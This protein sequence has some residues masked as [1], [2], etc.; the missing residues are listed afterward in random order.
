MVVNHPWL[1][2]TAVLPQGKLL[3]WKNIIRGDPP[4]DGAR[5]IPKW[6]TA[7]WIAGE[8]WTEPV[9]SPVCGNYSDKFA[10]QLHLLTCI[11]SRC[12]TR[13]HKPLSGFPPTANVEEEPATFPFFEKSPRIL[14]WF[15]SSHRSDGWIYL[16]Q[17]K[18]IFCGLASS[19]SSVSLPRV[20]RMPQS[21]TFA[22]MER[23]Q[24]GHGML[25]HICGQ[26]YVVN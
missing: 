17:W 11:I 13:K 18:A 9:K 26:F 19:G 20:F 21:V 5:R 3:G 22:N 14:A 6:T 23:L 24:G 10:T 15:T 2:K 7:G 12:D 25:L 8:V 4:E 16:C 1:A